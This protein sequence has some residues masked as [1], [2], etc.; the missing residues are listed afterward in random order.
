MNAPPFDRGW[1]DFDHCAGVASNSNGPP[2]PHDGRLLTV[3]IQ[4]AAVRE[5]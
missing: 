2:I 3:A 4:A 1:L 5:I